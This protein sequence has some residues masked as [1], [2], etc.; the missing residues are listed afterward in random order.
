MAH[1]ERPCAIVEFDLL[2]EFPGHDRLLAFEPDTELLLLDHDVEIASTGTLRN[3]HSD[4]DIA[5]LLCPGVRQR[6][7]AKTGLECAQ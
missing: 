1:T 2:A 5:Q 3:R 7:R 6:C 4:V